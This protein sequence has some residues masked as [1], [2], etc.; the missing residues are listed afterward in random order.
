MYTLFNY[1]YCLIDQDYYA[2]SHILGFLIG[3]KTLFGCSDFIYTLYDH[4]NVQCWPI[5]F[6]SG[7]ET[8]NKQSIQTVINF[9]LLL[10]PLE[11]LYP[12]LLYI[13]G[14]PIIVT[15]QRGYL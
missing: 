2:Q 6:V 10:C 15:C 5:C 14:Y 8:L 4:L 13:T 7:C 3:T 11:T 9:H 12:N 1:C